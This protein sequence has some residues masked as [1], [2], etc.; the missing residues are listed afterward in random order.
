MAAK[1]TTGCAQGLLASE[2]KEAIIDKKR[3]VYGSG[4]EEIIGTP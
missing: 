2:H 3:R 1:T 4:V